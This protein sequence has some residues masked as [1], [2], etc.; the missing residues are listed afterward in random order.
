MK[1]TK[2]NF[3]K[4]IKQIE[5]W[6]NKQ[7][8][9]QDFHQFLGKQYSKIQVVNHYRIKRKIKE[10]ED[11]YLPINGLQLSKIA[12]EADKPSYKEYKWNGEKTSIWNLINYGTEVIKFQNGSDSTTILQANNNW[13]KLVNEFDFQTS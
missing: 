1:E 10:L 9:R 5:E 12:I 13:V 6:K 8:S 11:K 7:I 2:R 4:E 3:D